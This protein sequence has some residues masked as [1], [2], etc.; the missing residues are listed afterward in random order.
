MS[1]PVCWDDGTGGCN[2]GGGADRA[3]VDGLPGRSDR[4]SADAGN[5]SRRGMGGFRRHSPGVA[6]HLGLPARTP[7]EDRSI[8]YWTVR[9]L[10][11]RPVRRATTPR[12]AGW[13]GRTDLPAE[14]RMGCLLY[15]S[16]SP[17]DGLL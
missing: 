6:A 11:R 4:T 10:H 7:E 16:P 15:T 8:G 3:V 1:W 14:A 12:G 2:G 9:G 5:R 17:R 13:K